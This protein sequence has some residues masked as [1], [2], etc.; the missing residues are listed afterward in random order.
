LN[1]EELPGGYVLTAH[2]ARAME[3]RRIAL[4]WIRQVLEAPTRV[5]ADLLDQA[6]AHFLAPVPEFGQRV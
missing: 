5:E 1:Q 4:G 6:T 2:A 3:R